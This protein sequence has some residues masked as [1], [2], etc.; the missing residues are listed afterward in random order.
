MRAKSEV[1]FCKPV[2]SDAQL[3]KSLAIG[4]ASA[5]VVA[6]L[7]CLSGDDEG[8]TGQGATSC[9]LRNVSVV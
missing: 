6:G 5:P 4:A 1:D 9:V 3:G 2:I 7:G 8:M